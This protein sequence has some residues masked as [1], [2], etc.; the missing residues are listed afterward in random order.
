LQSV[1][2]FSEKLLYDLNKFCRSPEGGSIVILTPFYSM[3]VGK[4]GVGMEVS[5]R[6]KSL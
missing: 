1:N 2:Y 3:E 4:D 6:R 5:Q